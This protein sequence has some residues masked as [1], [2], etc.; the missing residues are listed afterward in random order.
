MGEWTEERL[1]MPKEHGWQAKPGYSVFVADRGAARFNIPSGWKLKPTEGGSIQFRNKPEPDDDALLEIS[2]MHLNPQ[3]VWA[4]LPLDE[5][6]LKSQ[7]P[8]D[9]RKL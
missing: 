5:F 1:R 8:D 4:D 6:L 2:V 7:P 9:D 3:V